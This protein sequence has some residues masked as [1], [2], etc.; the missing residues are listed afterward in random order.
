MACRANGMPTMDMTIPSA[1]KQNATNSAHP[2]GQQMVCQQL[3]FRLTCMFHAPAAGKMQK[4]L[5]ISNKLSDSTTAEG[6]RCTCS[7]HPNHPPDRQNWLPIAPDN[8]LV[9][10]ALEG[11]PVH[12]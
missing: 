11:C 7:Y 5:D 10:F 8:E 3:S 9:Y 12:G 6:G 1:A 4:P 2:A